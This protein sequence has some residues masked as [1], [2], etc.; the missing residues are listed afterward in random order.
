MEWGVVGYKSDQVRVR[1]VGIR[2]Y[3]KRAER[4]VTSNNCSCSRPK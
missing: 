2:S 3:G 4:I 1:E